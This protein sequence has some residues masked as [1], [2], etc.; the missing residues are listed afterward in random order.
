VSN[1]YFEHSSGSSAI[2]VK[3]RPDIVVEE[4]SYQGERCWVCKDPLDQQYHRLNEQEYAIFRWLDGSV[5]FDDLKERFER[6]FSPYRVDLNEL[7]NVVGKFHEQSLIYSSNFRQGEKLL[8][9]SREKLRKEAKQKVLSIYAFKWKGFDPEIFLNATNPYVR[10][11]FSAP[12]VITV[13][14]FACLA[15]VFLTI[16]YETVMQRAPSLWSFIDT[17]N[18]STLFF[19]MAGTKLLHEL[20]HAYAFKRFGGEVHEI[21]ILIFFFMPTMYCN[22]SDSWMLKDKWARIAVA[23]GGVYVE[24][25][26]FAAATFIWWFSGSGAIQ[27]IAINLMFVCSLSAVVV[28][29]NPLLKYD[30]YFVL[31]DLVEIPNLSVDATDQIRRQFMVHALGIEDEQTPWVTS[32]NKWFMVTYGVAAYLFRASLMLTVALVMVDQ[33]TALGLA[34]AA[35]LFSV[36]ITIFYF[37]MPF[38]NLAKKLK[39]PGTIIK[40]KRANLLKLVIIVVSSLVLLCLPFPYYVMSDCTLDG[41]DAGAVVT[42]EPGVL[43]RTSFLPGQIVEQGDVIAE[44]SNPSLLEQLA[45]TRQ[46][47]ASVRIKLNHSSHDLFNSSKDQPTVQLL[48]AELESLTSQQRQLER[49]CQRLT[50][51]A[52]ITG[53]V[54]GVSPEIDTSRMNDERNLR[55]GH[56]NLLMGKASIWLNSGAELCR[57]S[58]NNS[59]WATLT[60]EHSNLDL[61][62][63]GQPVSVLFNSDRSHVHQSTLEF[64]SEESTLPRDLVDFETE[65]TKAKSIIASGKSQNTGAA[66]NNDGAAMNAAVIMGKCRLAD[67]STILFGSSGSAK[68]YVGLRSCLWRLHRAIRLFTN[69]KL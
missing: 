47:V 46:H 15:V 59:V 41:G 7:V 45:Q 29:G 64:L 58:P 69:T 12:A 33:A 60:I 40:I 16:N 3:H 62:E 34:P 49:R 21:G 36:V 57:I 1:S 4:V 6:Q 54:I 48:T 43:T 32:Y 8:E 42:Q 10:W 14:V 30:G 28:N 11:F 66:V 55:L 37:V 56:A 27:S 52:P 50:I 61:L 22:T 39:T 63:N 9:I 18:W 20:G 24:I 53:R 68:I 13:C 44:L 23:L 17:A 5:S 35:F 25:F 65:G 51:V 67:S 38:Y 31:S 2:G 26:I 19:V